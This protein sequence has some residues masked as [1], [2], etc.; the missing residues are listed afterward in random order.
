MQTQN[1][2]QALWP[3]DPEGFLCAFVIPAM[4]SSWY[5]AKDLDRLVSDVKETRGQ[6]IYIGLC[7]GVTPKTGTQRASRSDVCALP[8]VVVDI[9][10]KGDQ[11]HSETKLPET[12]EQALEWIKGLT[13][14][15][16]S[17]IV[18]T[19]NGL[20][21][22][23]LFDT[24]FMITD[25]TSRN[26]AE[27]LSKGINQFIIQ[28]GKKSGFHFDNVGDLARIVRVPGT[29]NY[30]SSPPKPVKMLEHSG[31]R[32]S[33]ETLMSHLL[34][35]CVAEAPSPDLDYCDQNHKKSDSKPQFLPIRAGCKFIL[36]CVDNA[37]S[38]P[39]PHWYRM[40]SIIALC[41]NGADICH[42]TSQPHP[43]YSK[44]ETEGK[45]DQSLN[46]AGPA[47]CAYIAEGLGFG[48]CLSC[49]LY[50]SEKMKS[51]IVLGYVDEPLAKLLGSYAYCVSTS[52]FC[53]VG[54]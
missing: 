6:N 10:I 19:G 42:E 2:I 33:F 11:A 29:F 12:K 36:H 48:G 52:Q 16:P 18:H 45:I 8:A 27:K 37:E 25:D 4:K 43:K 53:E 17:M 21:V 47:T 22:Y 49:P 20:H 5:D 9:D 34:A 3:T 54:A 44:E 14:P 23:W 1:F 39:E 40:I 46:A 13:L 31:E 7:P 50:Y 35:D 32:Y 15:Q 30:K 26:R 41:D 38:L 28:E 24:P 51:P